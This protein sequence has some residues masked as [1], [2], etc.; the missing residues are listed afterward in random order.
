MDKKEEKKFK[1]TKENATAEFNQIVEA[2]NFNISTEVKKRLVTMDIN[3]ISMSVNQE[4][5]DADS[6]IQKIMIGRIRFDEEA[7]QI[8]YALQNPI[9]IGE[10]TLSEFRFSRFTRALQKATKVP[11]NKCNFGTM[12]DKD[13]D[14]VLMGMLG[15]SDERF[16]NALTIQEYNDIRMIAG[17]FF[18]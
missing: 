7:K 8:V 1:L 6:F 17:Y 3:G 9:T 15:Q 12:E 11:L 4:L 13:Q 10:E 2:F 16:L 14:A 18:N 5:V